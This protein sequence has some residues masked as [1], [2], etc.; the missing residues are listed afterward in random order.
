[1]A[2]D[3]PLI[4]P[5]GKAKYFLFWGLTRLLKIGSDLPVRAIVRVSHVLA[6]ARGVV[7][8]DGT[9]GREVLVLLPRRTPH[10]RAASARN[11][12]SSS[13]LVFITCDLDLFFRLRFVGDQNGTGGNER[14]PKPVRYRKA[15]SQEDDPE[16]GN[17]LWRFEGS[18]SEAR[19][20]KS[21]RVIIGRSA[22]VLDEKESFGEARQ[23]NLVEA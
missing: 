17:K 10:A 3:M 2:I 19:P 18:K 1:M 7:L 5:S 12:S 23:G 13:L 4:W 16:N 14:H 8:L 11:A 21:L 6:N 15:L 22:V 9:C 20:T